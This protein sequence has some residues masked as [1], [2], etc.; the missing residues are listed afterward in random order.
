MKRILSMMSLL[1]VFLL[2]ACAAEADWDPQDEGEIPTMN[3]SNLRFDWN[4]MT[5]TET[6]PFD[7]FYKAG[8]PYQDYVIFLESSGQ[9]LTDT[10]LEAYEMTFGL[11]DELEATSAFTYNALTT[12]TSSDLSDLV[13]TA[14]S[15]GSTVELTTSDVFV[16][17]RMKNDITYYQEAGNSNPYLAKSEYI[18]A[19]LDITLHVQ[20]L[21]NLDLLQRYQYQLYMEDIRFDFAE[22]EFEGFLSLIR[23]ILDEDPSD[24]EINQ[25]QTAFDMIR[26]LHDST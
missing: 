6:H 19:R 3:T 18:K 8:A 21:Y 24:T 1:V 17:N 13:I 14:E 15:V 20:D 7:I 25:M 4:S 26:A 22:D 23:T 5:Y 10:E 9:P 11:F 2:A 16:F 12:Y